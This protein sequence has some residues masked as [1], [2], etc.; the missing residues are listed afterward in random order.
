MNNVA[1]LGEFSYTLFYGHCLSFMGRLNTALATHPPTK[2]LADLCIPT[3][4]IRT[5]RTVCPRRKS[6]S[7]IPESCQRGDFLKVEKFGGLLSLGKDKLMTRKSHLK[8][9]KFCCEVGMGRKSGRQIAVKV[10]KMQ[11]SLEMETV[12]AMFLTDCRNYRIRKTGEKRK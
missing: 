8:S 5:S 7:P 3:R 12:S 1:G 9:L 11:E 2:S 10:S 6:G 4:D